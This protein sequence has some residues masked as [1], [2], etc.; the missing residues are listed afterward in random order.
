MM[1]HAPDG[2]ECLRWVN[3]CAR[4]ETLSQEVDGFVWFV[5][6]RGHA[7]LSG[8]LMGV[9][10]YLGDFDGIACSCSGERVRA[11]SDSQWARVLVFG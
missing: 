5:W 2:F 7:R 11:P 6:V 1:V 4:S 9:H 10:A 8:F 3:G